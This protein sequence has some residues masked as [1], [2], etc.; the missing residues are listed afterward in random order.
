[1]K[2]RE[3][4]QYTLRQC[5]KIQTIPRKTNQRTG[6]ASPACEYPYANAP[7]PSRM[8]NTIATIVIHSSKNL[9][10]KGSH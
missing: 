2:A 10:H 4:A 8:L 9:Y 6:S 1:M 7:V 3:E 5:A